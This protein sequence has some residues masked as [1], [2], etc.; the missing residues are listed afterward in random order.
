MAMKLRGRLAGGV[1]N[2]FK[3]DKFDKLRDLIQR[4]EKFET[5]Q[6]FKGTIV[7]K[8]GNHLS[9]NFTLLSFLFFLFLFP[10]TIV[11]YFK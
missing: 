10:Q 11:I 5:P 8:W 4:I 1:W 7:E 2:V 6:R 9:D 3:T